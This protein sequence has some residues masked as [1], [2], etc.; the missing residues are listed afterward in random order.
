M[1]KDLS[2]ISGFILLRIFHVKYDEMKNE[3]FIEQKKVIN[4]NIII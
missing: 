3:K 2:L 1:D 4:F